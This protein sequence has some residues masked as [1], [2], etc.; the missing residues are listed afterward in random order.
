MDGPISKSSTKWTW[1]I[2]FL[3]RLE[4]W[5]FTSSRNSESEANLVY[6]VTRTVTEKKK[7]Q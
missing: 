6:I 3:K 7:E 1:Q 2:I 5:L 4:L